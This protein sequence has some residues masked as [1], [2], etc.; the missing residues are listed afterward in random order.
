MRRALPIIAII[1]ST[2]AA[3]SVDGA[4]KMDSNTFGAIEARDIGP[5]TMG[6]R[7]MA[8]DAVNSDPRIIYV[9]SASGGLWKSISGGTTFQPV[10]DKHTQS[11]GAVTVDQAHPGRGPRLNLSLLLDTARVSSENGR[12]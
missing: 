1:V 8:I 6:G 9:G 3:S 11:I 5:A 7:I 10:F 12:R 2:L 4:V